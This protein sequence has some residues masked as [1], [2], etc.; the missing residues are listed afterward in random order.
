MLFL[1]PVRR[2]RAHDT[3]PDAPA[4]GAPGAPDPGPVRF[5]DDLP[6][7]A[8]VID[9]ARAVESSPV[10]IVAGETGS[11]KTTQLPKICLAMGRG[12]RAH[13]G[14]TQPRRIAATSVAARV[15]RELGVELGAEV[16][17]KI[18]FSDRTGPGTYVKFMTDGILL[19]EIQGDRKLRA[20]DTIIVDEAH[21]RSL[22]I[23]FLLGYL[24][25]LLP[26][27]PDLRV[28]ISSATLETDRFSAFFGGAP[29]IQVSGRTYPVEVIYRPPGREESDLAE[30]V[31]ATVEEITEIDPREDIL[32]F[33]PGEREIHEAAEELASHGLPHT[34]ILPLYGRMPQ[35]D[36]A[37]IFQT[38]PERRIVLATN[39]AETSLTIPGIVYVVDAGLARVNR[40]VPRT[41]V[42]QLQIE[43][44]SRA[45]A[46]QRKGRAGR[47]RSGVCFRLYEQS[48]YEGRAA[49]TDPEIQRAGLA[50]AILQMKSLG[51][52]D[53]E[54]FPFLDPP[55]RR[56]VDEGRRV[57]EELGALDQ[58][59]ELTDIGKKLARLPLDPRLGRMILGGEREGALREVLVVAAALGVQDPRERPL[60]AQKQAD[61][62]HRELKDEASDF[63]GLL[64][65]F[66]FYQD[67]AE[68]MTRSQLR[69]TCRERFLSHLRMREWSDV[70]RQLSE[71]ARALGFRPNDRPATDEAI[72]RALLP[73]LLSRVGMWHPEQRVY[74]GARQTRFVLHP[75]SGLAKK[76]PPW[77]M[78][79]ELVET[80]Q[81][82]ARNAARVDPAWLEDIAGPLCRR[83]HGDPHWEQ[84][85]AQVMAS[86]SVTLYGLP[87]VR[88]RK[89]HY[90]PIDPAASRRLFIVHALVRQ[91]LAT[92]A[93][94]ME[95]NRR[96][97]DEA[98]RLC[99]RAR[100]SD[101]VADEHA[102]AVFFESRVPE[103]V[104]SG[105]TFE[106]WR[107]EAEARDPR[108][109]EL[110]LAD[111]LLADAADLTPERYPDALE[112]GGARFPLSYRFDPGE[113]DDGITLT[114]PLLLL[115]Q[116]DPGVL[117]WTIPGWHA[118]KIACLLDSLPKAI[119]KLLPPLRDLAADLAGSL[120][121]FQGRMLPALTEAILDGAGV[122]IPPDAWDL[123]DLPP[124][125][126][127]Y[128]RVESE[129]GR[130][131]G[132]G[133]DLR[134]LKDRLA[135]RAREAW[136]A[137]MG[138]RG[139]RDA[140][141]AWSFDVL[142]ERIDIDL[143]G[144]R[145]PG[146]P[147]LIDRE[148]SVSYRILESRE[149][150]DQ[151]TRAGLR[152]L[153]LLQIGGP[154][155]RLEPTLPSTLGQGALA[156]RLAPTP[157]GRPGP[158]ARAA[159]AQRLAL[160]A[161]DEV[162]HLGDPAAYPRTKAA[163][164]DRLA[165]GRRRLDTVLADLIRV[166]QEIGAELDR[167]ETTLRTASGQPGT[168]RAALE[169]IR[170][171]L[172]YL[173][174]PT[175]LLHTP[176]DRLPHI[177]RYL[178]AIK[179]RLDRMPH[180]PQKDLSKAEQ[181][182]PFWNDY[183]KHHEGLRARGVP[184]E[185]LDAFRWQI[186]ELRVS[187]FAPEL[188]TATPVSPQRLTEQWKR[189]REAM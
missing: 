109:L 131:L 69:K 113:D 130:V 14:C 62:A 9:I 143:P 49:Y 83:S 158:Q 2:R 35:A 121:P 41:G 25:R 173:V 30:S 63:A 64:R 67:A 115:P 92:K 61:Q 88:G 156:A 4:P 7:S 178:R 101:L 38:L 57:L 135:Q 72:H 81:L 21:E 117:E 149:A 16:G 37:R 99:D 34:V 5:P 139:A 11:G 8:R 182:I 17:Y 31:A 110:T 20:Y 48:D 137:A 161:V 128:F 78:A 19:A 155:A 24:K 186:E 150:A 157:L 18:R 187:L 169:D 133:R 73:G 96:V 163:F 144:G 6:I 168:P 91:E 95:A 177:P 166:A 160:R 103:G 15:A 123:A 22:N 59:G 148:A 68:R 127:F 33:L 105:K 147:A 181:V 79:A 112:I 1:A 53:I 58:A 176:M 134:D 102:L 124:H 87:I 32:V 125:L 126:R 46:D 26:E 189:I 174:P 116:A 140:L 165:A 108:I 167:V 175:L 132:E 54:D 141:T 55:A 180:G 44:I 80:S 47:L 184:A 114:L 172:T 50:G 28:I 100:K 27:R 185:D 94:F 56:A 118:E 90:G 153:Y 183:L 60:A 122:R 119:R 39:V 142:P 3:P 77:I 70:H 65:L 98:R 164:Q 152:R 23:D 76:P 188:K 86:E 12:L 145:I 171:Q 106:A 146:Y 93:P 52:G 43:P 159:L 71:L 42:T 111:V 151:A 82:F 154:V 120:R 85:P 136:S 129:P 97:F 45:S 162:F 84:R 138:A 66:R 74:L 51:L 13:I 75:S 170:T 40:Y 29:V 89:V 36:Q 107:K 179:I 104:Y 10:T